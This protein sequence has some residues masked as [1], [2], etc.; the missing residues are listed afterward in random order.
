MSEHLL[1]CIVN[2]SKSS[3]SFMYCLPL[4]FKLKVLVS[5]QVIY[6]VNSV[7]FRLPSKLL[8]VCFPSLS[9]ESQQGVEYL[10]FCLVLNCLS[11]HIRLENAGAAWKQLALQS[12][13]LLSETHQSLVFTSGQNHCGETMASCLTG[14][15]A[16]ERGRHEETPVFLMVLHISTGSY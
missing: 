4:S 8:L 13:P 5:V 14:K 9:G 10:V 1:C 2:K 7:N 6:L 15:E 16:A 3:V 11:W 12:C